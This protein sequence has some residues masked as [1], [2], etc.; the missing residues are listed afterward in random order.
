[1]TTCL[2]RYIAGMP[3]SAKHCEASS[4]ITRSKISFMG[5]MADTASG[6]ASQ[7]GTRR[8]SSPCISVTTL[9]RDRKSTRLNSSHV[10]ISY[11]VFCLKKK[12]KK[13]QHRRDT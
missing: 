5:K 6:D 8:R 7:Q 11:A 12:K 3:R 2:P 13:K 10:K 1:M 9:R 4:K